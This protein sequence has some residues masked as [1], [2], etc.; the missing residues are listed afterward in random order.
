MGLRGARS[1]FEFVALDFGVL[2]S[3]FSVTRR[4]TAIHQT[5]LPLVPLLPALTRKPVP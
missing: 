3:A 2:P 4:S 5:P 1:F